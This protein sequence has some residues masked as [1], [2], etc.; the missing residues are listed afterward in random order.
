MSM[1][2]QYRTCQQCGRRYAWNPSVGK[3]ACP[4]CTGKAHP[5][6]TL[7]KILGVFL[8]K[9]REIDYHE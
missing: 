5:E 8:R 2:P 9:K 3:M 4:Y 1:M 6:S 7:E